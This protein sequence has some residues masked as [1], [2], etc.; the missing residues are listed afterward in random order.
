MKRQ[1]DRQSNG[2]KSKSPTLKDTG[3]TTSRQVHRET[4][5]SSIVSERAVELIRAQAYRLFESRGQQ[6]G[7][8]LDDWLQAEREILSPLPSPWTVVSLS[9]VNNESKQRL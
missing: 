9:I 5:E 4:G 7:R 2:N 3:A 1:H 6:P 8:E